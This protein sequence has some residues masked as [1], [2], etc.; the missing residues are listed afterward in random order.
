MESQFDKVVIF[1]LQVGALFTV[2]FIV[3]FGSSVFSN[4]PDGEYGTRFDRIAM[5]PTGIIAFGCFAVLLVLLFQSV[6]MLLVGLIYLLLGILAEYIFLK[7]INSEWKWKYF[8]M[9]EYGFLWV[10]PLPMMI[11]HYV[12][13]FD[14]LAELYFVLALFIAA[15]YGTVRSIKDL[16]K[17]VERK[18]EAFFA[19]YNALLEKAKDPHA[20]L[21]IEMVDLKKEIDDEYTA[22]SGLTLEEVYDN[23]KLAGYAIV[24]SDQN[25]QLSFE[26]TGDNL[27]DLQKWDLLFGKPI[28]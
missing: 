8:L 28:F 15:V 17:Q 26:T 16:P 21:M 20:N 4:G 24:D 25:G 12:P 1:L 18:K 11:S 13:K 14:G 7:K 6:F 19:S 5:L 10:M 27:T 23:L 2:A 3:L 9:V 22:H